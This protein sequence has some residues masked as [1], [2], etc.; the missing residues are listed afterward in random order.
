[1]TLT[2][3]DEKEIG[4]I[5]LVL[6]KEAEGG[7]YFLNPDMEFTKN[8]IRGLLKMSSGMDIAHAPAV[9]PPE[10]KM[11]I[12]ISSAPAITAILISMIS[13][14]ATVRSMSARRYPPVK[15]SR[16]RYPNDDPRGQREDKRRSYFFRRGA[17]ILPFTT[18]MA[19][20]GLRV[21]LRP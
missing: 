20:H 18:G 4:K 11:K 1:M 16:L 8:L 14:P 3:V 13:G 7:G 2:I 10:T 21:S 19:V 17:V 9:S 5:F 15:R 6:K 12:S